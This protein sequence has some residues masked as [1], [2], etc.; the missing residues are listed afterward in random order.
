LE[1]IKAENITVANIKILLKKLGM[2]PT[3]P[4][5]KAGIAH[6]ML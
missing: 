5:K 4:M 1:S 6:L 2:L 3:A